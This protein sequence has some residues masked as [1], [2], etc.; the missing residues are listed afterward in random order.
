MS[1]T[2]IITIDDPHYEQV[3]VGDRI[4]IATGAPRHIRSIQRVVES[5]DDEGVALNDLIWAIQHSG[6]AV[7]RI[8]RPVRDRG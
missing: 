1:T 8:I 2:Q 5:R 4:V 6:W 7:E 3:C